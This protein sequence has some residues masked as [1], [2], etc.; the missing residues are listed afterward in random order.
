MTYQTGSKTQL[1][2]G[3]D[4]VFYIICLYQESWRVFGIRIFLVNNLEENIKHCT[5]VTKSWRGVDHEK[6]DCWSRAHLM[7]QR[8][9]QI[10]IGFA[11]AQGR[12]GQFLPFCRETSC[13][14]AVENF[15]PQ[16]ETSWRALSSGWLRSC[17][18]APT[19]HLRADTWREGGYTS[20]LPVLSSNFCGSPLLSKAHVDHNP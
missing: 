7:A 13:S 6:G 16:A 1:R 15:A 5:K 3:S 18:W 17:I 9:G 4:W 12:E 2:T 10:Q 11:L 8:A 19:A 14:S 20:V